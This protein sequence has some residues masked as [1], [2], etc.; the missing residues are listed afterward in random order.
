MYATGEYKT[1]ILLLYLHLHHWPKC[2]TPAVHY[3][4]DIRGSS[5]DDGPGDAQKV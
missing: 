1:S 3:R 4:T 5:T 2:E